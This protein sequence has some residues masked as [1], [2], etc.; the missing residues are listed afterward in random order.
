MEKIKKLKKIFKREKIDGYIIPKNDEFFGE[1]V[2]KG[3]DRLNYITN[4][5]GSYGFSIILKNNNYLFVDGR[6]TLQAKKESGKSFQIVTIPR[7]LPKDI[8]K[9]KRLVI[10]F[11]PKI[12]TN[13]V[14][15]KLFRKTN[16]NLLPFNK[17]FIESN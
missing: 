5:T 7:I 13:Q 11:D 8:L 4:F 3:N 16:C 9:K 6:Y 17:N 2:S 1:Y 15:V 12:F 10:G 14:L